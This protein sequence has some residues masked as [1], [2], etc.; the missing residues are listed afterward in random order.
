MRNTFL[1]EKR[2]YLIIIFLIKKYK[3]NVLRY[4]W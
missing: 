1:E 3:K 4:Y 2:N